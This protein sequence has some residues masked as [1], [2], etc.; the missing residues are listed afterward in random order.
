MGAIQGIRLEG[1]GCF[2]VTGR[3]GNYRITCDS[4]EVAG[5]WIVAGG[6]HN[7]TR[8][9]VSRHDDLDA[10]LAGAALAAGI[11]LPHVVDLPCGQGFRR[12]GR[13]PAERILASHGYVIAQG[14]KAYGVVETHPAT[15]PE[16]VH[17]EVVARLRGR[18]PTLGTVDLV[19]TDD[20]V[21]AWCCDLTLPFEG[22]IH[23]SHASGYVGRE[24][25]GLGLDIVG[26]FE[27]TPVGPVIPHMGVVIEMRPSFV[28]AA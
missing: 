15:T 27:I 9:R 21:S 13:I 19:E 28:L 7:V 20:R 10:A 4:V 17:A 5:R 18:A 24:T 6:P 2:A 1:D 8:R 11:P 22:P 12:P 3:K 16:Q 25:A 26:E 14:I 23:R